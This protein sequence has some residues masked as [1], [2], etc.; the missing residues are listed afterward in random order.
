MSGGE[1][2][3]SPGGWPK[4]QTRGDPGTQSHGTRL[5]ELAGLPKSGGWRGT[6]PPAPRRARARLCRPVARACG[7]GD[8]PSHLAFAGLCARDPDSTTPR[9][10]D[11]RRAQAGSP[12]TG[13][14]SVW[15]RG[16]RR[17]T[18]TPYGPVGSDGLRTS[19]S[20]WWNHEGALRHLISVGNREC[21][22]ARS[23]AGGCDARPMLTAAGDCAEPLARP[24]RA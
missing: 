3:P 12:R 18:G 4:R 22:V 13:R 24:T 19:L 9:S 14:H 10:S 20:S 21:A 5:D 23:D 15:P 8:G 16:C 17:W 6:Q 2:R 7:H 11:S 1:S